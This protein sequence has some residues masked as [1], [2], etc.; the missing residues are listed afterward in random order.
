MD[1]SIEALRNEIAKVRTGKA[2]TAFWME[3]KLII[4]EL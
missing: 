1:K 3:L 4:M 2:T